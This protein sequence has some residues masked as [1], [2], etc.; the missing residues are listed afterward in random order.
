MIWDVYETLS[1]LAPNE[2]SHR[3]AMT[4]RMFSTASLFADDFG[5]G[6]GRG[7]HLGER[8]F[9]GVPLM[10][11]IVVGI[12]ALVWF[13]LRSRQ[14]QPSAPS[15]ESTPLS[16]AQQILEERFA[17]GEIDEG[18]YRWRLGVLQPTGN[19]GPSQPTEFD[20]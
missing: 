19:S 20:Q 1:Y 8:W 11:L 5:P 15:P 6:W 3:E 7:D 10:V 17:R 13:L 4:T 12:G 2:W 9:I 16:P 18:E 14:T